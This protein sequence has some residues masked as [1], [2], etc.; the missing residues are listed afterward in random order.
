MHVVLML[1]AQQRVQLRPLNLTTRQRRCAFHREFGG[2]YA[3]LPIGKSYPLDPVCCEDYDA[4]YYT[5]LQ[6]LLS[7]EANKHSVTLGRHKPHSV[8][9]I[10]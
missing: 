3:Q 2:Y 5:K 4:I 8:N 7:T 9:A 10:S 6:N 1:T